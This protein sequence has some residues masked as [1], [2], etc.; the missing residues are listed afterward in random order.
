M[1]LN[2]PSLDLSNIEKPE[3]SLYLCKP[4]RTIISKLSEA[5]DINLNVKAFQINELEF[6]LPLKVDRQNELI[7]N[8]NIELAKYRYMI[9]AVIDN[10]QINPEYSSYTEY[11][12]I[13]IPKIESTEDMDY[14]HYTCLSLA[15]ELNDRLIGEYN[16][17]SYTLDEV[18]NGKTSENMPG[19]LRDTNWQI[20]DRRLFSDV[21]RSLD[22]K[23]STILNIILSYIVPTY[24]VLPI[25]DTIN[26]MIYIYTPDQV[27]K[28]IDQ[29]VLRISY[30]KY[31]SSFDFIEDDNEFTTRLRLRGQENTTIHNLSPTGQ[32]YLEDFS[33]FLQ[34]Y[35]EGVS[36][37]LYWS[38]EL[39]QAQLEYQEKVKSYEGH[40]T[41]VSLQLF[42]NTY[43]ELNDEIT[44]NNNE[45]T[46]EMWIYLDNDAHIGSLFK[47]DDNSVNI[48]ID[49]GVLKYNDIDTGILIVPEIW[50]HIAISYDTEF[51]KFYLNGELQHEEEI[52]LS[53]IDDNII[54][55][56]EDFIGAITELRLW[57]RI[58][59]S[60]E[61]KYNYNRRLT[62]QEYKLYLYLPMNE[63]LDKNNVASIL[64]SIALDTNILTVETEQEHGFITDD[65]I[66]IASNLFDGHYNINSIIDDNTFTIIFTDNLESTSIT[67]FCRKTSNKVYDL[68]SNQNIGNIQDNYEWFLNKTFSQWLQRINNLQ[69]EKADLDIELFNRENALWRVQDLMDVLSSWGNALYRFDYKA[70]AEEDFEE[71]IYYADLNKNWHYF[72]MANQNIP[73]EN[74]ELTTQ[75][76]SLQLDLDSWIEIPKNYFDIG[77]RHLLELS[78]MPNIDDENFAIDTERI[79]LQHSG[80]NN[81]L[82]LVEYKRSVGETVTEQGIKLTYGT[83]DRYILNF[84]EDCLGIID[85][86]DYLFDS[87]EQ[88]NISCNVYYLGGQGALVINGLNYEIGIDNNEY[89]YFKYDYT[90][91]ENT[92][93]INEITEHTEDHL[94]KITTEESIEDI[95][96]E[97]QVINIIDNEDKY[98]YYTIVEI[99]DNNNFVIYDEDLDIE[100]INYTTIVEKDSYIILTNNK[101]Q[102]NVFNYIQAKL[103]DNELTLVLNN[104]TYNITTEHNPIIEQSNQVFIGFINNNIIIDDIK[105]QI[106]N[107]NVG[108]WLNYSNNETLEELSNTIAE[109]SDKIIQIETTDIET[110]WNELYHEEI[111]YTTLVEDH[112]KYNNDIKNI[113]IL[114]DQIN[115]ANIITIKVG[116][117]LNG[118]FHTVSNHLPFIYTNLSSEFNLGSQ[119]IETYQGRYNDFRIWELPKTI[120]I[121]TTMTQRIKNNLNKRL[122]GTENGLLGYWPMDINTGDI[123]NNLDTPI[124]IYDIT[125]NESH[126]LVWNDILTDKH[127][128]IAWYEREELIIADHGGGINTKDGWSILYTIAPRKKLYDLDI[129]TLKIKLTDNVD[130]KIYIC[131]MTEQEF[132]EGRDNNEYGSSEVFVIYLGNVTEGTWKLSYK[133]SD[134]NQYE[135]NVM[136]WNVS[137]EEFTNEIHNLYNDSVEIRY[138]GSFEQQNR[139][140]TLIFP[141]S[142][143]PSNLTADFS[144]ITETDI[145]PYMLKVQEPFGLIEKYN[146]HLAQKYYDE[147]KALVDIKEIEIITIWNKIQDI[148]DELSLEANFTTELIE[149]RNNFIIEKTYINDNI[150]DPYD[151][152]EAGKEYFKTINEPALVL[153]LNLVNFM[154]M[155]ESYYDH[156]KLFY[157][158]FRTGLYDTIIVR[159]E[160]YDLNIACMILEITYNFENDEIQFTV[161]NVRENLNSQDKFLK[162]LNTASTGAAITLSEKYKW[163]NAQN[164]V[165]ELD[166]I[167]H[168]TWNT[169]RAAIESGVDNCVEIGRRGIRI[170]DPND[171]QRL[172]AIVAGYLGISDDGGLNYRSVLNADGIA[173][174]YLIGNIVLAAKMHIVNQGGNIDIDESGIKVFDKLG[175]LRIH[176]GNL[177][178]DPDDADSYGFYFRGKTDPITGQQHYI[179]WRDD[180]LEIAGNLN[181]VTG[182]FRT[183]KAGIPGLEYTSD[184]GIYFSEQGITWKDIDGRILT[185]II[186]TYQGEYLDGGVLNLYNAGNLAGHIYASDR[187]TL[188]ISA[189]IGTTVG[190]V[191][192]PSNVDIHRDLT[193]GKNA[194]IRGDCRID[195][196]LIVGGRYPDAHTGYPLTAPVSPA[197]WIIKGATYRVPV[198][199]S[200]SN[201]TIFTVPNQLLNFKKKRS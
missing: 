24:N 77:E 44:F 153:N 20:E 164:K 110:Y 182:T 90:T 21:Y 84:N 189:D 187:R 200:I 98:Y 105:I 127:S 183:L 148:R 158:A 195:G 154:G 50:K 9:K 114:R 163:D 81:N 126:N 190:K 107:E 112:R 161:S 97:N 65:Q 56:G 11:Y 23:D 100:E 102:K 6:K 103:E 52:S 5:Y 1:K 99:I 160:M 196:R 132:I 170:V 39:C 88:F 122:L 191:N 36:S 165:T 101:L 51:L 134:E 108:R 147:Q 131:R 185:E 136:N 64:K 47:T 87:Q 139:Y 80:S 40:L 176:I 13:S 96:Q 75:L 172:I 115:N 93:T 177:G 197:K 68:S 33:Y 125:R 89:C 41:D 26:R 72:I 117:W 152:L 69:R 145:F 43:I 59:F 63:L 149:E 120:D 73:V 173:A 142:M 16:V 12:R 104:N 167:L 192:I 198:G 111:L 38:D 83:P 186:R 86:S 46:I 129:D 31:L 78:L 45:F 70:I 179:E 54:T 166:E 58:R 2:F 159:H 116:I 76:N 109:H 7:N 130:T 140:F 91:E 29:D 124:E 15:E 28:T 171:P 168:D 113:S 14:K 178:D 138:E 53:T 60:T 79:V 155:I 128:W 181:A 118:Y 94:Y 169:A 174:K 32:P 123:D 121:Q 62:G 175:I 201:G 55:I 66:F 85:N 133:D 141:Y 4:D 150:I 25:F 184:G 193:V 48:H 151:L 95:L 157:E 180:T 144:N 27:G 67:G 106:N 22:V 74:I 30:K 49:N 194:Y 35:E 10:P 82:S 18:F 42:E 162:D 135:T 143:T 188:Q 61:I 3:I 137:L 119:T 34:G 8:S 19:I 146:E 92:F 199:S 37:S 71:Q 17:T 156:N 57:H